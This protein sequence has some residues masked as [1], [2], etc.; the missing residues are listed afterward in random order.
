MM[1]YVLLHGCGDAMTPKLFPL[2]AAV[3][4]HFLKLFNDG[5]HHGQLAHLP[6][7]QEK[8]AS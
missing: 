8:N 7:S 1:L 3:V 4:G 2:Q 5:R 6:H